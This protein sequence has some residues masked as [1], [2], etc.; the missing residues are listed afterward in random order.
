M[1]YIFISEDCEELI[2]TEVIWCVLGVHWESFC[3]M[4]KSGWINLLSNW[5][6][7]LNNIIRH[8]ITSTT[9]WPLLNNDSVHQVS[10]KLTLSNNMHFRKFPS[11][12]LIFYLI[13]FY[14][15]SLA[16]CFCWNLISS[17]TKTRPFYFTS[18]NSKLVRA[19]FTCFSQ[20]V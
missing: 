20:T 12:Y 17:V 11:A 10:S 19:G 3:M 13:V 7:L 6:S 1:I 9:I 5:W 16:D 15:Y 2:L 18:L 4:I 14:Y 8:L